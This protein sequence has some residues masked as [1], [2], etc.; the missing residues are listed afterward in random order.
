MEVGFLHKQYV[1][2]LKGNARKTSSHASSVH[3]LCK[4][5]PYVRLFTEEKGFFLNHTSG[6]HAN[7]DRE[8]N[9]DVA[10]PANP[11]I[12]EWTSSHEY[13]QLI[14]QVCF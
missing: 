7:S 13:Q 6:R 4:C 2:I 12:H 5:V 8:K 14:A 10:L 1:K 11:H 3:S 9:G